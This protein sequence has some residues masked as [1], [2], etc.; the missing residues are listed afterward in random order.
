MPRS[1][2]QF[3]VLVAVL[4]T[5]LVVTMVGCSAARRPAPGQTPG[6]PSNGALPADPRES[7]Q[8]ASR[9]AGVAKDV[10][11]VQD[12]YVVL[13]GT[14]AYVGLN[15][16]PN[17]EG[18]SKSIQ[19]QVADRVERADNRIRRV[20]VTTE[21]DVVTR[22]KGVSR[23]IADGK[24]VSAFTREISEINKRMTPVNR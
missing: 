5:L 11:G 13:T 12:A 19:Q 20:M 18:K 7:S 15:L 24:P 16:E 3:V 14:T 22:L 8:L 23:G 6:T 2:F 1:K 17:Q 10:P 4:L 21:P 9:L